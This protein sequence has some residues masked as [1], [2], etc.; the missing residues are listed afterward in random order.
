MRTNQQ[1]LSEGALVAQ[2]KERV[3]HLESDLLLLASCHLSLS[4]SHHASCQAVLSN[5]TIK[6]PKES[7]KNLVGRM[8]LKHSHGSVRWTE[9]D[10]DEN[11]SQI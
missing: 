7:E 4:L 9:G 2:F 8:L 10:A 1:T 11:K 5:K 3:H 6:R